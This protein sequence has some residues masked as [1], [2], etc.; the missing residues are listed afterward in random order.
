MGAEAGVSGLRGFSFVG[1]D[2]EGPNSD[3]GSEGYVS[4]TINYRPTAPGSQ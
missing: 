2:W 3:L 1:G 4:L